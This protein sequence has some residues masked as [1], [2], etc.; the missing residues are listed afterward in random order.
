V[1]ILA[2]FWAQF[3]PVLII[4]PHKIVRKIHIFLGISEHQDLASII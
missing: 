2:Y 1:P 4:T 3:W